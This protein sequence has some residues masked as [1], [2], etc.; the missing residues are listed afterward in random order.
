MRTAKTHQFIFRQLHA[1]NSKHFILV[2]ILVVVRYCETFLNSVDPKAC[3]NP[4]QSR[5]TKAKA[6][7]GSER[8][9][10]QGKGRGRERVSE[11]KASAGRA[12]RKQFL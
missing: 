4:L 3:A 12:K 10:D 5:S 7:G 6:K 1:E 11:R 8:K 9:K 2:V